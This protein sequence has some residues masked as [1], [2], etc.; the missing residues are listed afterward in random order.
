MT[1][2]NS[3]QPSCCHI[4]GYYLTITAEFSGHRCLDPGHWQ[5]AGLLRPRDFY[6]LAQI[7]AAAHAEFRLR[8][9]QSTRPH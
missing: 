2:I 9:H 5:A 8:L 3:Q 1:V 7:A 4:C 6:P